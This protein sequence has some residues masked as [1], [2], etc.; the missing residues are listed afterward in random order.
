MTIILH[1]T[2]PAQWAAAQAEGAYRG[3]TLATE[4][5]IHCSRP[6][7]AA[8]VGNRL[9][10]GTRGLI[11]LVIDR[12]QVT[13]PVKDEGADGDLFPHIYGPLNL[14]AVT[15]VVPFEPRPDGGFDAPIL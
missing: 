4:G 10:R 3:D 13:A 7:Q 8:G 6:E 11:V 5:F 9:F 1:I 2:T 12:A 14:D 15:H